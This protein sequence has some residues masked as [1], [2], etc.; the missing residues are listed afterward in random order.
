MQLYRVP[1]DTGTMEPAGQDSVWTWP[2]AGAGYALTGDF[3]AGRRAVYVQSP[4]K[5]GAPSS[6]LIYQLSQPVFI[7][8]NGR[9]VLL[10]LGP[11]QIR[12]MALPD[13]RE[14]ALA[15]SM[16]PLHTEDGNI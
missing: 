15:I 1:L 8:P 14:T 4:G 12:R 10:G 5:D 2:V 3:R 11:D 16:G 9:F 6:R 13:A 7:A